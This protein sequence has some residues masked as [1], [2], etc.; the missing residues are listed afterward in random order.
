MELP[1]R[2]QWVA[3]HWSQKLWSEAARLQGLAAF[4]HASETCRQEG[5]K[6]IGVLP[7]G[8]RSRYSAGKP[9]VLLVWE[10]GRPALQLPRRRRF[11]SAEATEIWLHR[12]VGANCRAETVAPIPARERRLD[13]RRLDKG[14]EFLESHLPVIFT[15]LEEALDL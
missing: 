2:L 7:H 12:R 5:R 14:R 10:E 1:S 8:L 4:R 15:E 13:Q 11:E 3:F 6:A 9:V